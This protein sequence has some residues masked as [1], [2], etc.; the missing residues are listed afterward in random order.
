MKTK[1]QAK[2]NPGQ[3]SPSSFDL[4]ISF[5]SVVSD[6]SPAKYLSC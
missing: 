4:G 5:L 6:F 1:K 2:T 3:S